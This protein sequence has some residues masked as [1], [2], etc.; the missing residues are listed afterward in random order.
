MTLCEFGWY[1]RKRGRVRDTGEAKIRWRSQLAQIGETALQIVIPTK[2][3]STPKISHSTT[4]HACD[5]C[6]S[7]MQPECGWA[8]YDWSVQMN[9][10]WQSLVPIRPRLSLVGS[11]P[12]AVQLLPTET[13]TNSRIQHLPWG[14]SERKEENALLRWSPDIPLWWSDVFYCVS[15]QASYPPTSSR[16][17]M[18]AISPTWVWGRR[19]CWSA[20]ICSAHMHAHRSFAHFRCASSH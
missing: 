19:V 5:Q 6:C 9:R 4:G 3:G 18:K 2:S 7:R 20:V 16:N 10:D 14:S 12:W 1:G 17:T 13:F 8:W 15:W 11:C